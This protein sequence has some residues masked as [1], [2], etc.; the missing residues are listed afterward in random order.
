M[1]P[2]TRSIVGSFTATVVCR[3][4]ADRIER[5]RFLR[6]P[7]TF[8]KGI[9]MRVVVVGATG[10][11]GDL[12]CRELVSAGHD[13]VACARGA[14]RIEWPQHI[15]PVDLDLHEHIS[16]IAEV[17]RQAEADAVVFTAGSRGKDVLQVDAMGAVKTIEAALKVGIRRYVM[18]GAMFAAD[19]NRWEDPKVRPAIDA[20][21]D[22]YVA[23]N[24]ADQHLIHT[25][26]DYTIIEPGTLIE[27]DGT[28]LIEVGARSWGSI[29][30]PDVATCLAD[31]LELPEAI[32]RVYNIIK[33]GQP[34]DS[35]LAAV[36]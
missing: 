21:A 12:T 1:L 14:S 28:G 30:I 17:Y 35:A 29:P 8:R 36:V 23:K 32:G 7:D 20:L 6:E 13:V 4:A 19:V 26:L 9:W 15:R 33:G 2:G 11:V 27:G 22:Y 34:I 16:D 25:D 31:C 10:R 24:M 5:I 3:F 18:L